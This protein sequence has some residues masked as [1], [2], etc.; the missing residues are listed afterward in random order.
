MRVVH[1]LNDV[2]GRGNGIVNTAVDLALEQARL[3]YAVA[4]IS[5]GGEYEPLLARAG[6]LHC[7]LD[8]SRRPDRL[9]RALRSLRVLLR[10]FAP[11]VVHAHMCTGLVLAW[12]CRGSS[13]FALVGHLHNVHD[14]QSILMGLADRVIAVSHSVSATMVARGISKDKLRVVLNRTLDTPRCAPLN[15]I[16]PARLAH[17][18]VVT[19]CG[20]THRKGIQ[21]LIAAFEMVGEDIADAHLYLVGDGAQRQL[22]EQLAS[23]SRQAQRIHF[24]GF[25]KEPRAYMRA[26][27]VFVLASRRESFGLVLVE[28]RQAGCAIVATDV[29][30]VAEAL[31]WGRAG[32]L[33]PARNALAL[34][35]ALRDLLCSEEERL[36][37]RIWARQG[38]SNYSIRVMASEVE[39]VYR[40]L[41]A[42]Q[43]AGVVSRLA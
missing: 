10:D 17:P 24:E 14:P 35:I 16:E 13:A 21:E 39:N 3:G 33:V 30:G 42:P 5:A 19:V 11:D 28:A 18:A 41:A 23:R 37:W 27:D 7:R 31:D 32:I 12:L 34:S 22:F 43:R 1:I 9:V 26:A 29:D 15:E 20:M 25:Q 40:E 4:V 2:T 38:I 8:Q 6:I 36:Q